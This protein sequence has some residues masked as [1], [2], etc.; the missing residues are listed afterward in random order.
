MAVALAIASLLI[1]LGAAYYARQ[2]AQATQGQL[3]AVKE[4]LGIE[5][6]RRAHERARER[7]ETQP[8]LWLDVTGSYGGGSDGW[9]CDVTIHNDG[10]AVAP[11][12]EVEAVRDG[13]VIGRGVDR[14]DVPAGQERRA[15]VLVS[16]FHVGRLG[17][18]EAV[19]RG[20]VLR[21]RDVNGVEARECHISQ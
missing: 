4:Q 13:E 7:R 5:R 19:G 9:S 17:G 2:Q 10:G 1:A 20:L 11:Q 8:D 16:G 12:V 6:E 3:D 18:S 21:A 15:H 14:V